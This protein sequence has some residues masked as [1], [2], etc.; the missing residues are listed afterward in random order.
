M[1]VNGGLILNA[2]DESCTQRFNVRP[3]DAPLLENPQPLSPLRI[4]VTRSANDILNT[5]AIAEDGSL[6]D[7]E[8]EGMG[9]EEL[10]R[11]DVPPH[12]VAASFVVTLRDVWSTAVSSD[13]FNV[14]GVHKFEQKRWTPN[15]H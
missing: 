11:D 12:N 10:F 8:R 9:H 7:S 13:C 5:L 1:I 3:H 4:R 6:P 2:I 14:L 15:R